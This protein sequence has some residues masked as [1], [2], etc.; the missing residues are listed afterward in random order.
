MAREHVVVVDDDPLVCMYLWRALMDEGY[1]VSTAGTAQEGIALV[2][3][4]NPSVI[5]LDVMLPDADGAVVCARL[6]TLTNAII[7]MISARADLDTR[8][9]TLD[10]GADDY[11]TKPFRLPELLARMRA[12]LRRHRADGAVIMK[13]ADVEVDP[14]ARIATRASRPLQL[15]FKEFELLL[16]FMRRPGHVL[17][18]ATILREVWPGEGATSSNSFEV[19]IHH[20]REKLHAEGEPP[21]L[22]TMRRAGYVLRMPPADDTP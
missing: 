1:L 6:R 21:L 8:V 18:R 22:H 7:I 5:L 10:A 19:H 15:T 4:E 12:S 13:F 11:L 3:Q 20:L 9:E 17:D 2:R 14:M 16:L